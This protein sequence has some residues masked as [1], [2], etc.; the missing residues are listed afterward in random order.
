MPL[1]SVYP[2]L[3]LFHHGKYQKRMG[4][5]S[6]NEADKILK[7]IYVGFSHPWLGKTHNRDIL[8]LTQLFYH[9]H[10]NCRR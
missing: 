9:L 8:W 7:A 4:I 2:R 6:L 3:F 10:L 1:D 5:L